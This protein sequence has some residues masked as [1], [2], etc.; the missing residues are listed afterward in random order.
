VG[1]IKPQTK[2]PSRKITYVKGFKDW[3]WA[4]ASGFYTDELEKQVE[5][6]QAE[7]KDKYIKNLAEVLII[8]SLITVV[9]LII[10]FYISRNLERRFIKYKQ[11]LFNQIEQNRVKDTMIAQQSKMAAMGEMIENIAHQWR[12]PLS[13]ISTI[14]SGVKLQ[15]EYSIEN[16]ED[17][18]KS[19]DTISSTTQYLSQT[20][21][22]F[23]NYFNPKKEVSDFNL[24]NSLEKICALIE[25]QLYSKNVQI[26]KNID[27]ITLFGL[28]NEFMQ[29]VI[30]ILSN[31]KDEFEKKEMEEKYI[32][33]D[34]KIVKN[35]ISICIKDNAGGINDKV[36]DKIFDLYFTRGKEK[37]TG[38]GLYMSK[39]IIEKH[40]K[41]TIS[42]VN[43]NYIFNEKSYKGA[44]FTITFSLKKEKVI[45]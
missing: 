3:N 45:S 8:S 5:E 14:S 40:M 10:S 30:N 2:Q 21:D 35:K 19:M 22:D 7:I 42:A 12:Q 20:I 36:I 34:T 6:K 29:V 23:R 31:S 4:I 17:V 26:I 38:I 9:F 37:G 28:E 24:K 44:S 41:G 33:I 16:R 32:F 27:D 18:I 25:P 1:T 43:E 13:A 11:Q 39:E 15:Y